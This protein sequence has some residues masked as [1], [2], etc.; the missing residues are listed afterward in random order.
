MS[1]FSEVIATRAM[2]AKAHDVNHNEFRLCSMVLVLGF[3]MIQFNEF[4]IKNDCSVKGFG[5]MRHQRSQHAFV[6]APC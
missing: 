5:I 6:L 3:E 1:P 4:R 2:I